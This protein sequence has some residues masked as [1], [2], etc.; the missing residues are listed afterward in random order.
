MKNFYLL[1]MLMAC[2]AATLN[3]QTTYVDIN[4]TGS[5]DGSSWSNAY[6]D[7]TTALANTSDGEIWVATG[8]YLPGQG[9][10][11]SSS[12]FRISNAIDLYGG[13]VGTESNI[14]ERD[15][16]ANPTTLSG[17]IS[18]DD[19]EDDFDNNKA[20]NVQH[21]MVVDSM[22]AAPVTI[23]GFNI[24]GGH[25][26]DFNDQDE[27]F[28]RGG[29]IISYN[30]VI[31]SNCDFY[32]NFARSGAGVYLSPNGGG[33]PNSTIDNCNFTHS[34][35]SSQSAGI[36][37]NTQDNV[38]VTDCNFTDN[39]TVRGAFYPAFCTNLSLSGCHFENNQ[40]A[41]FGDFGAAMFSWQNVG[42]TVTD[43]TFN[44]NTGGNGG[45]IYHDGRDVG[46]SADNLVFENCTFTDNSGID[47][48]GGA[49]YCWTASLTINNCTFINNIANNGSHIFT[50]G[51]DKEVVV[52]NS[53]FDGG[54]AT[55]G[56]AHNCYGVNSTFLLENNT[57][58]SCQAGTSGGALII[59]FM[60]DATINNCHFEENTADFGGAI[61]LQNDSTFF[62]ITNST[63]IS[64]FAFELGGA[65][66]HGGGIPATFDHCDFQ[67]NTAD[68]VGGAL[69]SVTFDD[70]T[71][72][73]SLD[74]SN[75]K[76]TFNSA[77]TQGGAV[78]LENMNTN[79][80]NTLFTSNVA[81][82][83]AGGA[84]SNNVTDSNEVVVNMINSTLAFNVSSLGAGIAQYEEL[85]ESSATFNFQNCILFNDGLNYAVELGE[86]TV[87]STGGNLSSDDSAVG[88]LNH[89]TDQHEVTDMGFVNV[90]ALDY[91]LTAQ[92]PAVDAGIADGAPPTDLD[93]NPRFGE[94]D[95]GA[96]EYDPT[97][98]LFG[99]SAIAEKLVV[100][101]NPVADLLQFEW[102][103]PQT[104]TTGVKLYNVNGRMIRA[105]DFNK[106]A[107]VIQQSISVEDLD[108]GNYYLLVSCGGQ[109]ALGRFVKI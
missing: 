1:A 11:D 71:F 53:T 65:V 70:D 38:S 68:D 24:T 21:V 40:T 87:N 60:A 109:M 2:L 12:T 89:A 36:Y 91:H 47:W 14:S 61:Y 92:S 100:S 16:A 52:T 86:P 18:G 95:S 107:T 73:G 78:N 80:S 62:D 19:V 97:S 3:A 42:W 55:F 56:G 83:A 46:I 7:L 29:G 74:L 41:N 49:F 108:S 30:T 76:F 66:Y 37:L 6:T 98:G 28:W 43:C 57:Y 20:D 102:S 25:T 84:I 13:F 27:F 63:F 103:N 96:Y 35:T 50:G 23:D 33:A 105:W 93:G 26:S 34:L 79:I 67:T 77:V 90:V 99:L 22:L 54:S 106:P 44:N 94:V 45:V 72:E 85:P 64:N 8:T 48:G 10:A 15:I 82:E 4:A 101:P 51:T 31:I 59:G 32:G 75:C 9:A 17:D 81:N 104:G 88:L 69:F 5:N 58:T 39:V